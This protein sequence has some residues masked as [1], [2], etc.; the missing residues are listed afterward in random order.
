M[1]TTCM[2]EGEKTNCAGAASIP[3]TAESAAAT[4]QPSASIHVTRT[5]RSRLATGLTAEAR[6]A[7]PSLVKLKNAQSRTTHASTTSRSYTDCCGIWTSPTLQLPVGNGEGSTFSSGFQI[8]LASPFKITSN[9]IVA[10]TIVSS[11]ARAS[12]RTTACWIAAPPR[13]ETKIVKKKAGQNDQP[14]FSTSVHAM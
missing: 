1:I 5:P 8:Q 14:W 6:S 7:N 3:A 9:A 2:N 11:P 13:N 10:I 12:G 4:P